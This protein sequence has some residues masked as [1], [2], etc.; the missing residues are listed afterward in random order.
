MVSHTWIM[1]VSSAHSSHATVLEQ[2]YR[3]RLPHSLDDLAGPD[4]GSVQLPLHIAWSG[5]T[6]FDVER[7]PLCLSMYHIVL[8]EGLRD[9][10]VA[11]LN[12]RL[13]VGHWPTLRKVVGRAIREAWES[14][15]PELTEGTPVLP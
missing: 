11:F 6:A 4:R 10:L 8:T 12:P 1:D 3:G 13:L 7:P 5:L 9:D 2:R 15:F 14:A